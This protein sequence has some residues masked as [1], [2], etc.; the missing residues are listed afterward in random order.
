MVK[1]EQGTDRFCNSLEVGKF[2]GKLEY[3]SNGVIYRRQMNGKHQLV[4]PKTMVKDVIA[5]NHDSIY[6]A[7][8]GRKRTLEILCICYYWPKMRQNVENYVR[9]CDD[10]RRKQ[11][12]EYTAPLGDVRQP[13]YPFEITSVDICG[14]YPLT[15]RKNKYLLTFI[16]HFTKYV[17]AIPLTDMS[18]E[19]YA[20]AYVTRDSQARHR[21]N[22]SDRPGK[23]IHLSVFQGNL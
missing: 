2:K 16:D 10:Y 3:F 20:R 17:K 9:E 5:L 12:R 19:T 4:V 14:P 21:L 7:H 6:A 18:A 11:G 22:F 8:P 15:P 1:A 13:T 23:V